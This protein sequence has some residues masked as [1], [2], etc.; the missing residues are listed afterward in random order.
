MQSAPKNRRKIYKSAGYVSTLYKTSPYII[1][2]MKLWAIIY[3]ALRIHN[4]PI[5]LSDMMRYGREGHLSYY[6]LD[7][8]MPEEIR[9]NNSYIN[10]LSPNTEITHKGMRKTIISMAKFLNV[11]HLPSVN[12]LPL[13]ERYCEDLE[14]PST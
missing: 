7:H 13:V 6:K 9:L 5:Q 1:T 10:F 11:H 14:L 2:P 8:L 3:L 12:L 4:E